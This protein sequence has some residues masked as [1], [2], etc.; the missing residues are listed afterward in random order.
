MASWG[1]VQVYNEMIE[2]LGSFC[3]SIVE[4]VGIMDTAAT[5]CKDNMENDEASLKAYTNVAKSEK[6]YLEAAQMA[7]HLSKE[8]AEER[9]ALIEYLRGL[10]ELDGGS[11]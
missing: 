11:E 8:L 3:K 7:D 9:D 2:E 10:D 5:T 4:A 6:L 1:D